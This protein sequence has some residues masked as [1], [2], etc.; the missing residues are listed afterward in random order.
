[1]G[2]AG[3]FKHPGN[4]EFPGFKGD[5]ADRTGPG[6]I[7]FKAIGASGDMHKPVRLSH[8]R[9]GGGFYPFSPLKQGGTDRTGPGRSGDS[10]LK[11]ILAL[12]PVPG[13]PKAAPAGGK[14]KAV[15]K[16][17]KQDADED[18]YQHL[19]KRTHIYPI[20][21]GPWRPKPYRLY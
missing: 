14:K 6:P 1:M 7:P 20:M 13:I 21:S 19:N 17:K 16:P 15:A 8:G 5:P 4:Q 18:K 2:T 12:F 10:L 9:K 11:G 3:F